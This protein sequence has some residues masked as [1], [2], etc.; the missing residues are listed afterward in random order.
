MDFKK[1]SKK[2]LVVVYKD[3]GLKNWSNKNKRE[4]YDALVPV[5]VKF[6][7]GPDETSG[8]SLDASQSPAKP[9]SVSLNKKLEKFII[10]DEYKDKLD[11][12]AE[13]VDDVT[14]LELIS[15]KVTEFIS[16]SD[17]T[18]EDRIKY[19]N[20]YGPYKAI[21]EY[22]ADKNK[23]GKATEEELYEKIS[24]YIY[25]KDI[26]IYAGVINK[27]KK[28]VVSLFKEKKTTDKKVKPKPSKN[29]PKDDDG[30]EESVEESEAE[31]E[32]EN[33]EESD[34]EE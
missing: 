32:A 19:V 15:K 11:K 10:L 27:F 24:I 22:I 34:N 7:N 30:E 31:S 17:V 26:E 12:L 2:E 33:G 29:K 18:A 5:G 20:K 14:I 8:T 3:K 4:L 28:Y 1:T 16:S 13:D 9:R 21:A 25:G 6:I 23:I